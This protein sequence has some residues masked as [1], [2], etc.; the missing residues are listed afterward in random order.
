LYLSE[1][2]RSRLR[3]VSGSQVLRLAQE[4]CFKLLITPEFYHNVARLMCDPVGNVRDIIIKKLQKALKANRLP[5]SYMAYFA[6][7]GFEQNRERR[8]RVKKIYTSLVKSLREND[9][10]LQQQQFQQQRS[11]E[12]GTA[13]VNRVLPEM[14]LAYAISL[15]AHNTRID[16]IKDEAKV[17]QIRE[18]MSIALDPLLESPDG[19]QVAYI[20]KLLEQIKSS[21]DGL[22]AAT[23]AT[24]ASAVQSS[25]TLQA[26]TNN[27]KY[28]AA[29]QNLYCINK[30]NRKIFIQFKSKLCILALFI[31]F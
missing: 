6:L 25:T 8:M 29:I 7:I 19:Y 17:K 11:S 31:F 20:M 3:T 26:N 4:S 15:L 12:A 10:K 16:S 14:C 13:A 30:V 24:L 18:C 21:D 28:K 9:A 27:S 23:V 5:V 22:A 1:A 2:E